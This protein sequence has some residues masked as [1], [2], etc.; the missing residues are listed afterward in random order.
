MCNTVAILA[1]AWRALQGHCGLTLRGDACAGE[2]VATA[3]A[4]AE[5]IDDLP[6][7]SGHSEEP[8]AR[9]KTLTW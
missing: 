7:A 6:R 5:T 4:R 2:K 9:V 1:Q 8:A 3:A